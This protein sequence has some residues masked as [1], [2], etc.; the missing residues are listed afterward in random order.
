MV[1]DIDQGPA[2]A[3]IGQ[4]LTPAITLNVRATGY[5]EQLM[6][7]YIHKKFHVGSLSVFGG[8]PIEF[9]QRDKRT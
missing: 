9:A 3:K 1:M 6:V 2:P 7:A 8:P 4:K 5:N